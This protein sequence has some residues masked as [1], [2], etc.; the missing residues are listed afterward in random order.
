MLS[1]GVLLVATITPRAVAQSEGRVTGFV[2]DQ[3]GAV[4]PGATVVLRDEA[5]G[6]ELP[7][8]TDDR[9]LF[10]FDP[11]QPKTYTLTIQK[12]G[13]KTYSKTGIDVHPGDRLDMSANLELGLRAERVE[14]KASA[15]RLV[16]TDSGA[17]VDVLTAG[18]IQNLSTKGRNSFELLG[19][20]AGVVDTGFDPSSGTNLNQGPSNFSVNGQRFDQMDYRLDNVRGLDP[21]GLSSVFVIPNMDMIQ[22]F[23]VKT[24]NVEADQG[25]APVQIEAV[26]KSGGRDFHGSVYYYGRNAALNANDFSNNLAGIAKPA[27]KFNYPGFT[28]GG[29]VRIPGTGFNKNRDK[30]FFFVGMEWQR[31][32]PD[33]GTEFATVPTAKMRLHFDRP[34]GRHHCAVGKRS[35][36][37]RCHQ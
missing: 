16:P 17:K 37:Q 28:L 29:P 8:I 9:G 25:H 15:E 11:V 34:Q 18:Q 6:T 2:H 24:S 1:I 19:L 12:E 26:T 5:S 21:G 10:S 27:S 33:P 36:R 20:L 31:Q 13:F 4:I 30:L 23:S 7:G 32:L 3:T 22:E 35:S 14:V